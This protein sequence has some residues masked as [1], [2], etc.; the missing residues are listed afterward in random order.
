MRA[1]RDDAIAR[2]EFADDRRGFVTEA[3]DLHGTPRD[4][5]RLPFN[6]PDARSLTGI[7][8][9][10]YRYMQL[11]RGHAVRD[12][13][14]DGRAKWCVCQPALQHV[15]SLEGPGVRVCGVRQLT[16]W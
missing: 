11:W 14:R 2:L 1:E 15:P 10:A 5:R 6:Q 3:G 8:E 16:Q 7:E 9:R 13:D 4:A 12:V